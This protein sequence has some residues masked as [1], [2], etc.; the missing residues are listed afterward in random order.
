MLLKVH[1]V[2]KKE[3]EAPIAYSKTFDKYNFLVKGQVRTT[4]STV[5][6]Y[7]RVLSFVRLTVKWRNF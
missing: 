4:W 5:D 2:V 6:E 1:E 7:A 3:M